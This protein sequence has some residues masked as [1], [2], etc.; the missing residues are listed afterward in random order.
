MA[1]LRSVQG[2]TIELL[3]YR[4]HGRQDRASV[5]ATLAHP[6]NKGLAALGP[7]LPIGT[8]VTVPDLPADETAAQTLAPTVSLWE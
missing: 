6:D 3:V 2:D 4:V 1:V 8:A 7:V 5:E